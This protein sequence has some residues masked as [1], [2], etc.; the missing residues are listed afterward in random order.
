MGNSEQTE[1]IDEIIPSFKILDSQSEKCSSFKFE[2]EEDSSNDL[3]NKGF[4]F[5]DFDDLPPPIR[6]SIKYVDQ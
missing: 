4:E 3:M 2:E 6:N 5:P 1:T